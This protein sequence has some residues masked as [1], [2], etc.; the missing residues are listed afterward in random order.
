MSQTHTGSVLP[1]GRLAPPFLVIAA[2]LS[3]PVRAGEQGIVL[4]HAPAP[5]KLIRKTQVY[6]AR[7]GASLYAGDVIVTGADSVQVE[8]SGNA[9]L[10][11]GPATSV[12][13]D[14]DTAPAFTL[15]QGW[16]KL[17]RGASGASAGGA[18]AGA[19]AVTAGILAASPTDSAILHV[20]G[21]RTEAF[22]ETGTMA[23]VAIDKPRTGAPF[24][25]G[26]E[27]YLAYRP[28]GT[29]E[30]VARAP[31]AFLAGMPR[32]YF[33]PLVALAA[34]VKPTT[35]D[36]RREVDASD[37]TAWNDAAAPLREKLTQR[38][39]PHPAQRDV[40]PPRKKS[41]TLPNH[42]F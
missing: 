14:N 21:D 16:I 29:L 12:V 25:L 15:L 9:V 28:A 36:L 3:G 20:A 38:F 37:S 39:A 24:M 18:S 5:L 23:L 42:L 32:D 6:D 7:A 4:T 11:L 17:Q 30:P 35:P 1:W 2:L 22:V 33:D 13:I 8:L 40:A 34:R 26:R 27:Q 31:Q 19:P 10:A 41:V